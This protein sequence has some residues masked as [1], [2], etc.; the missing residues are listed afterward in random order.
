ML[1]PGGRGSIGLWWMAVSA[2]P[3]TLGMC[4]HSLSR[5]LASMGR[6]AQPLI[7]RTLK[8]RNAEV[9]DQASRSIAGVMEPGLVGAREGAFCD[10][11]HPWN[12]CSAAVQGIMVPYCKQQGERIL[13]NERVAC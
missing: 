9:A 13:C 2:A 7:V 11:L 12:W 5:K 3:C 8:F 4:A 10:R 1:A 6:A